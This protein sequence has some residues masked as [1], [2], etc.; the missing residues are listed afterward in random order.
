MCTIFFLL[1]K[2]K[3]ETIPLSLCASCRSSKADQSCFLIKLEM[4]CRNSGHVPVLMVYEMPG[5]RPPPEIPLGVRQSGGWLHRQDC[6][7]HQRD[8][9]SKNM[10]TCNAGGPCE[11][12]GRNTIRRPFFH[13]TPIDRVSCGIIIFKNR[14]PN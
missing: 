12:G 9:T 2:K 4:S 7:D 14:E 1:N 10:T 11:V 13:K 8:N 5:V 6:W 3:L